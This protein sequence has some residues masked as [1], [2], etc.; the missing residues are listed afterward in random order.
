MREKVL[1]KF[2]ARGFKETLSSPEGSFKPMPKEYF[3]RNAP[4]QSILS[5][6][7]MERVEVYNML[8]G[9]LGKLIISVIIYLTSILVYVIT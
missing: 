7:S 5:E 2:D 4:I 3:L 1:L 9:M 8:A 6:Y